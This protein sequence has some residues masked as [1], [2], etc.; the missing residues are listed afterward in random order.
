VL[1]DE[2]KTKLQTAGIIKGSENTPSI[3]QTKFTCNLNKKNQLLHTETKNERTNKKPSYKTKPRLQGP[4]NSNLLRFRMSAETETALS[5]AY[6]IRRRPVFGAGNFLVR[7]L[8]EQQLLTQYNSVT[9]AAAARVIADKLNKLS[10]NDNCL[11]QSIL[12]WREKIMS[13][14]KMKQERTQNVAVTKRQT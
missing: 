9:E 12:K 7:N 13:R 2:N 14:P 1:E 5:T 3:R 6:T 4:G 8:R 10:N 11:L